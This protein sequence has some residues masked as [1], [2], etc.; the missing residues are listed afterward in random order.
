LI[1]DALGRISRL[2]DMSQ[3]GYGP[4]PPPDTRKLHERHVFTPVPR[5]CHGL[6]QGRPS[7]RPVVRSSGRPGV[8]LP[9][10]SVVRSSGC[11]VVRSSGR[12]VGRSIGG[13]ECV[14]RRTGS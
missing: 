11:S 4:A 1:S 14:S 3:V 5:F 7:G 12:P 6:H 2:C 13:R 9:G 8:R 10:R